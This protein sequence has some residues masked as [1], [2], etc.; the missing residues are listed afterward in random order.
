[1]ARRVKTGRI[2][3]RRIVL[4]LGFETATVPETG[5]ACKTKAGRDRA[6]LAMGILTMIS[7]V[8]F[9]GLKSNDGDNVS[10]HHPPE[11]TV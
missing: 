5:G 9:R 7:S 3:R 10:R 2:R 1:M 6:F 4:E 11:S 8:T